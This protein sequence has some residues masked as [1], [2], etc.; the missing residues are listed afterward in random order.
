[1]DSRKGESSARA[2][3]RNEEKNPGRARERNCEMD[4]ALM[5]EMLEKYL[6]ELG[7]GEKEK[8]I[9]YYELLVEWNARVNLTAITDPEGV[10]A[11]H[12]AD[13]IMG[14]ALIARGASVIDIG[15]GAGF[16]GIPLKIVRPDIE[17]TLLD[18]LNKR[19]VFIAE[20]LKALGLEAEI[21]HTRAEDGGRSAELRERFDAAVSRAVANTAKIAEL[22]LPFVKPGGVSLLYKG[23][24][25]AAELEE[26]QE[27]LREFGAKA[28][29]DS[30]AAA[31]GERNIIILRKHGRAP[32]KYPRRP[33]KGL[34]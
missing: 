31:W 9:R 1:M 14:A 28:E 4:P 16:P 34:K 6:P 26:A 8:L 22:T 19:L 21:I 23:P 12:F 24:G 27:L 20:V 25:A 33:G 11:R 18:S 7:A 30:H 3:D 29:I 13:S 5:A 10:A 15:T 32:A 2:E 17:L